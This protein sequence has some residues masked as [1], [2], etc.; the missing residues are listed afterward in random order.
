M[1][2][3]LAPGIVSP[4]AAP[5]AKAAAKAKPKAKAAP[6]AA[7]KAAAKPKA[8]TS[9]RPKSTT[10]R[11][12]P[13]ARRAAPKRAPRKR[14][15]PKRTRPRR[16]PLAWTR[17]QVSGISWRYRLATL[18]ILA[19]MG[20][21]GYFLWLRDSSLVAIDNV[22][23]VG[24]TAGDRAEIIGQLTDASESMTTLHVDRAEL[25]SI[26]AQ[27]PTVASIS[28]DPNFPHGMRIEVTERPPTM[29][30]AAGDQQVPVAADGTVLTGVQVADDDHLPVLAV[31]KAPGGAVLEGTEL[32]EALVVGAAP[33]EL[34]PLISKIE[35]TKEYGVELTLRGGIPVRFGTGAAAGEKWSAVSAVL[36]DPKLTTLNYVDVR[37]PERPAVGGSNTSTGSSTGSADSQL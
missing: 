15:A 5:K 21:A 32:D 36:A 34:R 30:V 24:V 19:V 23:V 22:D 16:S 14:A 4:T 35:F 11:P 10:A 33:E 20:A 8:R 31:D 1:L 27:F 29:I 2:D 26:A 6:K 9:A 3:D 25:Q 28:I 7:A 18:A 13:T 12:K 37:V 17:D